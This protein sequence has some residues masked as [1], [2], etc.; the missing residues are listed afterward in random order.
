M[1]L[2]ALGLAALAAAQVPGAAGARPEAPGS[3]PGAQRAPAPADARAEAPQAVGAQA[4]SPPAAPGAPPPAPPPRGGLAPVPESVLAA[5]IALPEPVT[6]EQAVERAVQF[7]TTSVVAAQEIVR[8][9]GLMGQARATALPFVT[10]G[11]S[12]T[13]LDDARGVVAG[14]VVQA[15]STWYG[16]ATLSVPLLAPQRWV[17]WIH[18]AQG[19]DVAVASEADVRRAV[20]LTA[21]RAY[22]TVV[23]T[24]RA[25]DV[26]ES[27]VAVA[28]AHFDYSSARRR[29]GVGNE[30]D[31]RRAE[32]EMAAA[33]VQ[34]AAARTAVARSREALGVAC[35]AG[36][37]LD[38]TGVP[39]IPAY[40][41]LVQAEQGVD[42][43]AD[44]KAARERLRAADAVW[45][46][47]WV[48]WLP[49]LNGTFTGF[50]QDP[51]TSTTPAQGWVAQ[52]VLTVPL[53][54]GGLRPAQSKE[55]GAVAREAEAALDGALRQARSE[56]RLS[57]ES[58]RNAA[59]GYEAS[60]RGA[61]SASAALGL[62]TEAYR[63]G[64]TSNLDVIDAERRARD[65]ALISVIAEDAVRQAKLD[66]LAAAGRFP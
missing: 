45:R 52:L 56:V 50:L 20:A 11:G 66:L 35:G 46:D 61:E 4:P 15:Q 32:Q 59:D 26:S 29:G 57:F 54:E 12:L 62:A 43:R 25:V 16:T 63:A 27:A 38:A 8:A 51:S 31:L 18:G 7:A 64:A 13:V 5:R 48:D 36:G 22:L 21:A 47:S 23:A 58:L 33:E 19:V 1:R 37:P 17:A 39:A 65:A 3:G 34:L 40:P 53:L 28:R 30:L 6:F 42:G 10:L 60:R 2:L 44:V 41:D 55:R 24:R 49:I 14:R 9:E